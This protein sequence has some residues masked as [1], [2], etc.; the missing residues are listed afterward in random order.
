MT[1]TGRGD[2]PPVC[3]SHPDRV[4]QAYL[5]YDLPDAVGR[6]L[7]H[8]RPELGLFMET[9][10]WPNLIAAAKSRRIPLALI[11][12]RLSARSQRGYARSRRF[13]V[14]PSAAL[15]RVC[16]QTAADAGTAAS[17]WRP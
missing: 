14:R 2:G 11:N 8:F 6:F 1:P 9:E 7:D 5:P 3:R 4:V 10:L 12:A 17:A 15:D 16:A 13:R